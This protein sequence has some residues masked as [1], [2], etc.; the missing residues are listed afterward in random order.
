MKKM[1]LVA[2]LAAAISLSG[3]LSLPRKAVEDVKSAQ[4]I[5]LPQYLKYVDADTDPAHDSGWKDDK[6][7][8]VEALQRRMDALLKAA[9]GD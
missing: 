1:A 7:K 5:I 2:A 8:Q 4:D 3:C 6:R 9:D